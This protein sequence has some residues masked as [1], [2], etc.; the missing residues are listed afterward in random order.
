MA[1]LTETEYKKLRR[2]SFFCD[3]YISHRNG[4]ESLPTMDEVRIANSCIEEV[5]A[6]A[7]IIKDSE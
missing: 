7:T 1:I 3:T 4:E 5:I 6:S 2:A